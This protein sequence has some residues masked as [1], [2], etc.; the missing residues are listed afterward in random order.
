MAKPSRRAGRSIV[1]AATLAALWG[2]P[3]PTLGADDGRW[4][5]R[6]PYDVGVRTLALEVTTD[7]QGRET[8]WAG[9]A[10]RD[11]GATWEASLSWRPADRTG[12]QDLA[13]V[14][15]SETAYT[16]WAATTEGVYRLRAAAGAAAGAGDWEKVLDVV[17]ATSLSPDP[18]NPRELL[19]A[20]G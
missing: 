12:V 8:V 17:M 20:C 11:G 10:S 16:V 7:P 5:H 2:A 18:A 6:G 1:F 4:V 13:I 9:S 3:P 19:A 15:E 14:P